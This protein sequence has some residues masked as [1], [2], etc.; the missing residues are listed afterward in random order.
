MNDTADQLHSR[1]AIAAFTAEQGITKLVHFTTN[2]GA[3]GIFATGSIKSRD[4]L[5]RDKYIEH[6]YTPNCQDRLKD[7]DWTG[8]V[9]LSISRVNGQMLGISADT[10]HATEDLWWVILALDVS[11]LTDPGVH[12]VTT[13]NTYSKCLKRGPGVDALRALF[14]PSVE[15]GWYGSRKT[16]Y[17]GMLDAWTTDPQAEV[18]YPREVPIDRIREVYVREEHH[19][20]TVRSWFDVFRIPAVPVLY[21]PD[22]FR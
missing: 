12:F 11:L 10:W 17:A 9:N 5:D 16:R 7:A 15:W 20:D 6:I 18:L 8:H 22:E 14:A 21:R 13:N 3:L 2:K 19:A 4:L 1:S